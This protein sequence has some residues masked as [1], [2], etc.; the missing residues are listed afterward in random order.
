VPLYIRD[1]DVAELARRLQQ[2]TR[3]R[4]ITDAV[5]LALQHELEREQGKP[6]LVDLGLA[7]GRELRARGN[8]ERAQPADKDFIDA[9]YESDDV[10]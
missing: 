5:R 10:R 3:A 7:F 4:T 9:L 8:P 1:D 6:S 2:V